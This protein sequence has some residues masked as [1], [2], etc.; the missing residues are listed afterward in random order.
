MIHTKPGTHLDRDRANTMQQQTTRRVPP[1]MTLLATALLLACTCL[2]QASEGVVDVTN[3]TSA[4][5]QDATPAGAAPQQAQALPEPQM[6]AQPSF[7]LQ[8]V[9]FTGVS[10]ATNVPEAELQAAVAGKIGQSVTFSDLE[11]LAARASAV[12]AVFCRRFIW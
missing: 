7:V 9:R 5:E 11:Q 12:L 3:A 4:N 1:T 8:G 10:G 2:A 6:V